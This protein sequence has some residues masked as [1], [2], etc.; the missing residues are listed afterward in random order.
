MATEPEA[1]PLVI[2]GPVD[3]GKTTLIGRLLFDTGDLKEERDHEI[4]EASSN[5]G[6]A[7][8]LTFGQDAPEEETE[9]EIKTDTSRIYFQTPQR[10]YVILDARG[11]KEFLRDMLTGT[12][13][14]EAAVLLI[15]AHE[16][17]RE[18]TKKHAYL[19][20]LVGIRQIIVAVNKMDLV[21]YSLRAFDR[22]RLEARNLF[23]DCPVKP[24]VFVPLSARSGI[25][26]TRKGVATA[27]YEGPSLVEALDALDYKTFGKRPFRFPVQDVLPR[28]KKKVI[29]GR[30]ESGEAEKGME[31]SILP[32]GHPVR[33][34]EIMKFPDPDLPSASCGECIGLVAEGNGAVRRGEVLSGSADARVTAEFEARIFW[35]QG[36][37]REGEKIQIRCA[38]QE[39]DSRIYLDEILDSSTGDRK[40]G[41][42]DRLR[43][44]EI[45]KVKVQTDGK[46]AIDKFS[47]IPRMGRF[48][49]EK[50]G[51]LVGGGIVV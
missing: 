26:V 51:I 16:G 23:A 5:L 33:I 4:L 13:Y 28:G 11:H 50:A 15:D 42:P 10:K 22:L 17:I 46:M 18:Q 40:T 12:S 45:A 32:G 24:G 36:S 43:V 6:R 20:S 2:I 9:G 35:L 34:R 7:A 38:T 41:E 19:L 25:N 49:L 44:G 37:Y 14:A 8:E 21:G 27:W 48:T 1:L 3:H 29:L 30:I 47:H 31:V 39:R